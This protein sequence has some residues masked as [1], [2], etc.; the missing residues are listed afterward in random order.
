MQTWYSKSLGTA[1]A[2]YTAIHD[3]NLLSSRMCPSVLHP[4]VL[5]IDTF[6]V[7]TIVFF[8]PEDAELARA[9]GASACAQPVIDGT[10]FVDIGYTP[11]VNTE[12]PASVAADTQH[13][14]QRADS[15][16]PSV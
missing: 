11:L 4:Y 16:L 13:F 14:S 9:F 6:T 15:T 8:A 12:L 1:S 10:R 3:L 5:V 7:E 2:V